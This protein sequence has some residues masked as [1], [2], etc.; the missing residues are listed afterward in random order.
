MTYVAK[1]A[2]RDSIARKLKGRL[3]VDISDS[4]FFPVETVDEELIDELI[5]EKESYIDVILNDIYV[6]PLANRQP[7]IKTLVENLVIVDLLQYNYINNISNSQDL[8]NLSGVLAQRAEETI[9]KLTLGTVLNPLPD[10]KQDVSR[11]LKLVGEVEKRVLPATSFVHNDIFVGRL[12]DNNADADFLHTERG[13]NN[14]FS[15]DWRSNYYQE[16]F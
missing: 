11:R 2:D 8:S 15:D 1:Y 13:I 12:V 4:E 16:E 14:P 7:I 9:N 6:L 10:G 5:E 3:K